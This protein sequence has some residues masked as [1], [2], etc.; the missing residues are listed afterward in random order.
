[1]SNPCANVKPPIENSLGT[2]LV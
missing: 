1:M 2:V